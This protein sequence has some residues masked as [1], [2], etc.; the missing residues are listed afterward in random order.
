MMWFNFT[1][2]FYSAGGLALGVIGVLVLAW[3]HRLTMPAA[4]VFAH[5]L[6]GVFLQIFTQ[7]D[8]TA[9]LAYLLP[10]LMIG[11]GCCLSSST[12]W[13]LQ[14]TE[15]GTIR[16][17]PVAAAVVSVR[18]PF[19]LFARNRGLRSPELVHPWGRLPIIPG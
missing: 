19:S 14:T 11:G 4:G 5:F 1:S 17:V 6:A 10:L 16:M 12:A 3:Q 8:R 18:P 7:Y 13:M 2:V 9:A 15:R